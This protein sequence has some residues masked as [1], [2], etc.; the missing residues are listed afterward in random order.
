MILKTMFS[1]DGE[2]IEYSP[3]FHFN[4]HDSLT[5]LL[6]VNV[7]NLLEKNLRK[8]AHLLEKICHSSNRPT[9]SRITFLS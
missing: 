7:I 4:E 1:A 2:K 9:K 8:S 6:S 3:R 5:N